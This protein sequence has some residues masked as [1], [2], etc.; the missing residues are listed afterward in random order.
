MRKKR[1]LDLFCGAG[2]ASVGYY[3]AGFEVV[4]M[5]IKTQRHYPF[6]FIQADALNLSIDLEK[7]D[8]IH[9][10]P[11]CQAYSAATPRQAKSHHPDL[12]PHVRNLLENSR[13][14]YVIENVVGS[15][16]KGI[17]LC[18]TMFGLKDESENIWLRRHRVFESSIL[19]M[20]FGGCFCDRVN[21]AYVTGHM[22]KL[23]RHKTHGIKSGTENARKL[24]GIDWMTNAEIVESIPPS[25]TEFIGK[26]LLQVL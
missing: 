17:I 21:T 15:P 8:A 20:S 1:L 11:P 14:A 23:N 7:F 9:A 2:G 10:S 4:G 24:M 3:R 18:G 19:L 16:L 25:F 5:D 13:K 22:G 6:A 26:Q 12:I